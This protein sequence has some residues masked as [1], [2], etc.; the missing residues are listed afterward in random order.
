L[1]FAPQKINKNDAYKNSVKKLLP[2]ELI[3]RIDELV[4]FNKLT[5]E[6]IA[7]VFDSGLNEVRNTLKKQKISAS[8]SLD[9]KDFID[10]KSEDHARDIKKIIRKSIEVPLAKFIMNNPENLDLTVKMLDGKLNIC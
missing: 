8:F 7:K 1:G 2:P 6:S 3:S 10:S 4:V 5:E 9:V